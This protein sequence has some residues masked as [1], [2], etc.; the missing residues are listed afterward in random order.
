MFDP[1]DIVGEFDPAT[2]IVHLTA[3][4]KA[5]AKTLDEGLL[6]KKAVRN[7]M[8]KYLSSS[9]GY[10]VT[11]YGRIII[12]PALMNHYAHEMKYLIDTYLYPRGI[13]RYG[14]DISRITATLS[15]QSYIGGSPNLFNTREEAFDYIHKLI[16]ERKTPEEAQA[17]QDMQKIKLNG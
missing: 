17:D 13:A 1:R 14:M 7:I 6:L 2:R 16:E 4:K 8:D 3:R 5:I 15:H 10:L 12:D 9:R 11:D